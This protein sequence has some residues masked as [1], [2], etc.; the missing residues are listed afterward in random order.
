MNGNPPPPKVLRFDKAQLFI[1]FFFGIL[2]FLLYQLVHILSPFIGALVVAATFALIFFPAHVWV[3]KRI[4]EN[5]SAAA[6]ISTLAAV[7]TLALPLL[8]FGWLLLNESRELYP[9]TNQWLSAISQRDLDLNLPAKIKEYINLDLDEVIT[10]NLKGLQER[11]TKSGAGL[12]R[13]IFFFLVN[14]MVMIFSLFALFRDGERFL[15]WFIDIIPMDQEYKHRVANQLYITT[16]AVVRGLLLTAIIQGF[17]GAFGY[18]LAGVKAPA[19]FGLLTSFAALVP[20]VGTSLVW[21]PLSAA[22]FYLSGFNTGLFVLLWGAVA[23]GLTDN[24]LRPILI[25]KGAKLPIFLLFLGI[26]GGMK[27]YG[28]LGL[29]LGPLLISCVIVFLQI[30]K[31]AKNLPHLPPPANGQQGT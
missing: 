6:A 9:K 26:I 29:F 23:V 3:R 20:F 17:I 31:E 8:I 5:R 10:G 18:W 15:H 28:P 19:L 22:M 12:L 2:L 1:F 24:F 7:F 30:Y 27:V 25:G 4:V 13:N 21:L 16:M 14:F 11:I